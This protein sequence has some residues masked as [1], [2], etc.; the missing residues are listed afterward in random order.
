VATNVGG[1]P[2]LV[3]PAT[4]ILIPPRDA[5]QLASALSASLGKDWDRPGIATRWSRGWNDV[6]SEIFG[7]CKDLMAKPA[8]SG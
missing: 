3:A 2:D 6:A 8:R 1:T 5:G 4:G 7:I